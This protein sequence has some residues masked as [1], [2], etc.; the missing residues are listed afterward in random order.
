MVQ[1]RSCVLVPMLAC[2]AALITFVTISHVLAD[3]PVDAPEFYF[4]RLVYRQNPIPHGYFR[5][6]TMAKPGPYRCPEFGGRNF[7]PPQG[8]GWATDTPGADCKLMGAIHRLTGQHVYPNPNY[9]EIMDPSLFT[10][11]FAYIVEP[12]QM[13]FSRQEAERLRE[14]LL[15]GGFLH[16]DDFWGLEQ[17]ENLETELKKVFPEYS[18]QPLPLKHEIFHTFYDIDEII[19]TPN[20]GQ[21]CFGGRTWEQ[22]D[23]TEPRVY[24]ITDDKGRLMVVITYNTDLGDAWEFMDLDCYP[25]KYSGYAIRVA[26]NFMIYAMSH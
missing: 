18:I 19:Q 5:P 23:D 13:Y 11:P 8:W 21:G 22:P 26:L 20:E 6:F 15:R 16:L 24:G 14:Y 1:K 9:I 3:S 25:E 10:F 17:K 7:F 12:G 4:T 2:V